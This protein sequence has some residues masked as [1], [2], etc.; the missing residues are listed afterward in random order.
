MFHPTVQLDI[1]FLVYIL[2]TASVSTLKERAERWLDLMAYLYCQELS[3]SEK[4]KA[5][6]GLILPMLSV[7]IIFSKIVHILETDLKKKLHYNG[8]SLRYPKFITILLATYLFF[9]LCSNMEG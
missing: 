2:L 1:N 8:N 9:K 5:H 4:L 7:S 6:L 3:I